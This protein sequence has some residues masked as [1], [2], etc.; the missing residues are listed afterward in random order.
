MREKMRY[1]RSWIMRVCKGAQDLQTVHRNIKQLLAKSRGRNAD[2]YMM[3]NEYLNAIVPELSRVNWAKRVEMEPGLNIMDLRGMPDPLHGLV[4]A[5]VVEWIH[6]SANDTVTIIPEAWNFI[7]QQRSGPVKLIANTLIRTGGAGK[8]FVWLDSQDVAS[9]DKETLRCCPVWLLG[10][11]REFNEVKRTLAHMIPPK[12]KAEELMTLKIGQFFAC[13]GETVVK[14][15][16]KPVWATDEEAIQSAKH[17]LRKVRDVA[18][19]R[20]P[21]PMPVAAGRRAEVVVPDPVIVATVDVASEP[22]K[23]EEPKESDMLDEQD[24]DGIAERV[25]DRLKH[26]LSHGKHETHTPHRETMDAETETK[27]TRNGTRAA[28]DE[29]APVGYEAIRDRLLSDPVVIQ[30]LKETKRIE[31]MLDTV[32]VQ[33][34]SKSLE[35]RIAILLH[36]GFFKETQRHRDAFMELKRTGPE[37]N[38]KSLAVMLANFVKWGFLSR[39]GEGYQAVADMDVSLLKP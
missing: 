27:H 36:K 7:P 4:I 37:T 20:M 6:H 10:V 29:T 28:L 15:Y 11:Q 13:F 21:L 1:E 8:N 2:M 31:V 17:G 5:S 24:M 33:M 22:V 39:E 12:P 18:A 25:A 32:T 26:V 23:Q 14:T 38:N 30:V 9:V 3:L 19:L 16:V 34:S 35:G